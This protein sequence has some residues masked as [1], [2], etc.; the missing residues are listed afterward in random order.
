M[1]GA[2][3]GR[4]L[5]SRSRAIVAALRRAYPQVGTELAHGN[6]L[7]LLVATILSAQ[8][9]DERVNRVTPELFRRYPDARAY[10]RAA[11][12][13]LEETI[14]STGFFRAK[15]RSLMGLGR[16][17][18]DRFGG[19]VPRAMDELV[20]LPGVGRKT[21]NVVRGQVFGDPA[22]VVDT[23]VKRLAGRLGLTRSSD[24]E[25]IERDLGEVLATGDWT[26][27]TS[28]LILHGRRVCHARTPRCPECSL[29]SLCPSA[30][31]AEE[32]RPAPAAKRRGAGHRGQ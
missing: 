1:T 30:A 8:C 4:Q 3:V 6:A 14:R 15:A 25:E 28:A 26:F 32:S 17:L 11:A 13:E 21:A 27:A 5:R 18:A 23:H 12:A 29:A 20:S 7:E 22:L 24:P 2:A 10:A 19:E 16:E 31:I 9:T